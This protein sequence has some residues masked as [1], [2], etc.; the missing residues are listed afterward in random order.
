[1]WRLR[2]LVLEVD[3]LVLL[4]KNAKSLDRL[5]E[6]ESKIS[7][8]GVH[9]PLW[10]KFVKVFT[11]VESWEIRLCGQNSVADYLAEMVQPVHTVF[12]LSASSVLRLGIN[13]EEIN[14]TREDAGLS[15]QL[16]AA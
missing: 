15:F 7:N 9:G 14:V 8:L 4:E 1:M 6:E 2:D 5:V 3:R 11:S 10:K 16:R 13:Q 12:S